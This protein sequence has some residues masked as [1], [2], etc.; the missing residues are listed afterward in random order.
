MQEVMRRFLLNAFDSR[1]A[2]IAGYN[3]SSLE[4]A[5]RLKS[6]PGMRLRSRASSMTAVATVSGW[7]P[8]RKAGR[9]PDATSAPT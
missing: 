4:L 3:S 1:S 8:M 2:I 6:N 9:Q 7:N 5:R